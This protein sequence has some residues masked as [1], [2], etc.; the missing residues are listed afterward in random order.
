MDFFESYMKVEMY[1]HFQNFISAIATW[2]QILVLVATAIVVKD[3]EYVDLKLHSI[4]SSFKCNMLLAKRKSNHKKNYK[5]LWGS[6]KLVLCFVYVSTCMRTIDCWHIIFLN[7]KFDFLIK[8]LDTMF[9]VNVLANVSQY[10]ITMTR[11]TK[12]RTKKL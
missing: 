6:S 9:C 3:L 8:N 2:E 4:I 5:D 10:V 1:A 11:A 12:K 7:L